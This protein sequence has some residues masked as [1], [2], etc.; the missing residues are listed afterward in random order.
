[1]NCPHIPEHFIREKINVTSNEKKYTTFSFGMPKVWE[2]IEAFFSWDIKLQINF[3]FPKTERERERD[4]D[5][6]I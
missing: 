2:K 4:K 3:L 1:M 5:H 6:L